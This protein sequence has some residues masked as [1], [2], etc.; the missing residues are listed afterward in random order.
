MT[1]PMKRKAAADG[2]TMKEICRRPELRR[3]RRVSA[4]RSLPA[5]VARDIVGSS[6]AATDMPNRLIGSR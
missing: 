5:A 1:S 2:T 3:A 6:A 4:V